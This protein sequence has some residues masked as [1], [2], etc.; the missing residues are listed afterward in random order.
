ME[1]YL[2]QEPK[3][4]RIYQIIN[5]Q[6]KDKG[7]EIPVWVSRYLDEGISGVEALNEYNGRYIFMAENTGINVRTLQQWSAAFSLYQ[8]FPRK[9]ASRIEKRLLKA[10]VNYPDDEYGDFFEESVKAASDAYYTGAVQEGE[11]WLL[12][13]YFEEDGVTVGQEFY[14][15][16]VLISIDKSLMENQILQIIN[17]IDIEHKPTKEQASAV[18]QI[19]GNFFENF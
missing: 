12:Q 17:N 8:D 5:Y 6:D 13:Q 9:V 11:F 15:F 14:I 18:S 16:L 4:N 2:F 19:K 7:V 3:R 10:A 1:N